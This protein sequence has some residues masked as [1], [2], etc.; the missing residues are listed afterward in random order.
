[1]RA[2]SNAVVIIIIIFIIM[3]FFSL[4]ILFGPGFAVAFILSVACLY[5]RCRCCL[6]RQVNKESF[7]LSFLWC[8]TG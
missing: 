5:L 3:L 1:M 2:T 7:I 4:L 6:S 8:Y